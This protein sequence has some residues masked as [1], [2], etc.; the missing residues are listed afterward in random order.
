[1]STF[2]ID[3]AASAEIRRIFSRRR[4][5][6]PVAGLYDRAD[7]GRLGLL[8]GGAQITE[9]LTATINRRLNEVES[10]LEFS[11]MVRADERATFSSEYLHE[12]G[13]VTFVMD[14]QL[15]AML[16]GHCLTFERDRFFLI[17]ADNT[18]HTLRSLLSARKGQ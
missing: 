10:Q 14:A 11:L 8:L 13:G 9:D 5:L 12:V 15:F 1:M 17:S 4:C 7:A 18:A 16:R 3:E 6:D 2:S